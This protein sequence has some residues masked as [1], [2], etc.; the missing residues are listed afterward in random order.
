[1]PCR[2]RLLNTRDLGV[3]GGLGEIDGAGVEV[4]SVACPAGACGIRGDR[5]EQ[6]DVS[7]VPVADG[8]RK[9]TCGVD[10]GPIELAEDLLVV[11]DARDWHDND[12]YHSSFGGA[13]RLD[14]GGGDHGSDSGDPL[15]APFRI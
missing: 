13:S 12:I 6:I 9:T 3:G 4:F 8:G 14:S 10:D 5:L 11:V 15:K 2:A 1:M 7:V